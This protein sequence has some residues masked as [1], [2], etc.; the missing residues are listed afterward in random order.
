MKHFHKILL[1]TFLTTGCATVGP[2]KVGVLWTSF[3]GTQ[4]TTYGE[5]SHAVWPWNEM[6]V[7][8]LRTM[9]HDELLN[10]IASNGLAIQLDTSVRYH[11][12]LQQTVALQREI[13]PDYYKKILE[14]VLR[15]EARRVIGQYTPE[16]IYSTKR[17]V[18]ERQIREGL[19]EK[20]TGKHI[21]LEAILVRNV[22]LPETIRRAIDEKLAAE[23]EMFKMKFVLEVAKSRAEERAIEAKGIADYNQMVSGSLSPSVLEFERIRQIG[24]L[25]DS[26]NSKT[27][28]MGASEAP[29]LLLNS[30]ERKSETVLHR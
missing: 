28:V 15:S 9:N 19:A 6:Y 16:E 8:D 5:G 24:K 4:E 1:S 30:A 13:G 7:Y 14:P 27:V 25:A 12:E 22:E 11:L 18:I 17:D 2:G 21:V 10:V 3:G 26:P 20:I 23:Q 29:K